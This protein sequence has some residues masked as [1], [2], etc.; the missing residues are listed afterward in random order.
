MKRGLSAESPTASL[1]RLT[2]E[3]RL[4]SK[5]TNVSEGQSR[6]RSSSRVTISP[7]RSSSAT[8]TWKGCPCN[9]TLDAI[10]V[11]LS[12]AQID[13]KGA[14]VYGFSGLQGMIGGRVGGSGHDSHLGAFEEQMETVTVYSRREAT[15]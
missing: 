11:Q 2:A 3:F 14:K 1:S 6:C 12:G 13:V 9:L 7:G 8:R 4:C 15:R 5:S 10:F